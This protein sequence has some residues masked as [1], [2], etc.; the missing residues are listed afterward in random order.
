MK[1]LSEATFKQLAGDVAFAQ[2]LSYYNQGRVGPLQISGQRIDCTVEG[3]K[4]YSVV[5][6][7]TARQFEGNC[8]CPA[9]D[10]FDFCKHCVAA[11]LAYYYQTQTNIE[12]AD[13]PQGDKVSLYL[14]TLTKPQ[15]VQHLT[16]LINDD[17]DLKDHWILRAELASGGLKPAEIR[18]RITKA[19]PY[20][21]SGL[22][23]YKDV[24]EYF[25]STHNDLSILAP[26]I[27]ALPPETAIKLVT[28]ALQRFEK[29][30]KN[31]EDTNSYRQP[32]ARLLQD[33]FNAVISSS[34]WDESHRLDELTNLV[35]EPSFTYEI[36]NVPYTQ[37]PIIGPDGFRTICKTIEKAWQLLE[38]PE[39]RFGEDY[40]YYARLERL[41]VQ[42]ARDHNDRELELQILERGALHI[43]RCLELVYLSI[44]YDDLD[45]ASKWLKFSEQLKRLSVHELYDVETAQIAVWKA[46]GDSEP[47]VQ[48]LWQRFDESESRR[49]LDKLLETVGDEDVVWLDKAIKLLGSRIDPSSKQQKTQQRVETLACLYIDHGYHE[50]ARQ[51]HNVVNFRSE[52]ILYLVENSELDHNGITLLEEGINLLLQQAYQNV[53]QDAISTLTQNYNRCSSDYLED[54]H[55]M[56]RRL[57]DLP[58][59]KRKT[60]FIKLLKNEFSG[61]F[62]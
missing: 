19:I 52:V 1:S 12:I 38:L 34:E 3:T 25:D 43:E 56:V 4:S 39:E 37:L 24:A 26:A 31:I 15:L 58:T 20:R 30:L 54:F 48:A 22:W 49:D 16:Q 35:L 6:H 36:V 51:L 28:Y 60:N 44:D 11:S 61:L 7:H 9:S 57:Y 23:R 5:L 62:R 21:A 32:T 14:E 33:L 42:Q 13:N 27:E 59:N 55:A 40:L 29:T 45:R 8:N 47:A 18:K 50:E 41:L 2:G 17:T 10:R 46:R 53:Y